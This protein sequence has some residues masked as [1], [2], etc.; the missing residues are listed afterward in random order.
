MAKRKAAA[1]EIKV[2]DVVAHKS[3]PGKRLVVFAVDGPVAGFWGRILGPHETTVLVRTYD[4]GTAERR[5]RFY[6]EELAK[7]K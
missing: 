4:E 2:G 5:F 3:N 1:P 7:I 6:P